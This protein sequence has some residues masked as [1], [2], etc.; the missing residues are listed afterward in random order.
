LDRAATQRDLVPGDTV[1]AI[2][3]SR[4]EA[5]NAFIA[6]DAAH[7]LPFACRALSVNPLLRELLIRS[8]ILPLLYEEAGASSRMVTVLLDEIATAQVEK[9]FLPMPIDGRLRNLI[10]QMVDSP[11]DRGTMESW[12]ERA[13]MSGR[14]FARLIGRA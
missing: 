7:D 14:T 11:S 1:H 5:Y 6:A 8:A 9:L 12:A 10:E 4:I 3:G 2:K 13:G